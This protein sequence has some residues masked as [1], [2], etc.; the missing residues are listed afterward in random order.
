MMM[1][2]MRDLRAVGLLVLLV[3]LGGCGTGRTAQW[4]QPSPDRAPAA[5]PSSAPGAA[6]AAEDHLAAAEAAWQKRGDKAALAEAI[7]HFEVHLAA[8]PDDGVAWARLARAYYVMAD[9]HLRGLGPKDEQYLGAF[10]KGTSAGERSLL[11]L[12]PDFKKRMQAEEKVEDAIQVVDKDGLPGMY[13]YAVNLGKWSRAKGLAAL[14]G[15]KDRVK[16]VMTRALALDETFFHGA[17]HRYFGA[18]WAL[19]PVGRDLD[20]SREHFERSLAIAPGYA[21][22]K[23][24]MAENYAVKKQDRALFSRLLDE[25]LA[26][27]DDAIADLVAETRFEKDK[28]RELKAKIDEL[29]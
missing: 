18:Y 8:K 19:L 20:K 24:L 11:A 27:P 5:A 3:P 2:M 25:V 16:G 4:E 22:T 1:W 6:A 26:M 21:G 28:A 15:N 12:S 29:F 13:W 17:P 7:R 9:G 14:L 23:V 10:E